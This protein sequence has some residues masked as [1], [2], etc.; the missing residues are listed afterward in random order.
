MIVA[1]RDNCE[2]E[3]FEVLAA[4]DGVEGLEKALSQHPDVILL[5][6]MLRW[7]RPRCLPDAA[8]ARRPDADHHVDRAR[9]RTR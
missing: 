6:V 2:F 1:L 5:D 9:T 3:G 7:E 8:S 4:A